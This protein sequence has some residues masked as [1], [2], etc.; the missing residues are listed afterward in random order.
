MNF[1]L[2][3]LNVL[4]CF[5]IGTQ[6][7][8]GGTRWRCTQ[9]LKFCGVSASR[10]HLQFA[11]IERW[12]GRESGGGGGGAAILLIASLNVRWLSARKSGPVRNPPAR[13][14]SVHPSAAPHSKD[15]CLQGRGWNLQLI[16]PRGANQS[17]SEAGVLRRWL[18]GG[19]HTPPPPPPDHHQHQPYR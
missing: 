3:L 17:S 1:F 2:F 15:G 10:P 16:S 19:V 7:A 12:C 11:A 5:V 13:R 14:L 6:P 8:A 4:Q 9:S 18:L